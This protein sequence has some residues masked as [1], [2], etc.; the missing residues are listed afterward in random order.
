MPLLKRTLS[1]YVG[2]TVGREP[3]RVHIEALLRLVSGETPDAEVALPCDKCAVCEFG[4]LRLLDRD[5]L[6]GG[7]D[8]ELPLSLGSREFPF[9]V[10]VTVEKVDSS[11]KIHNLSIQS[12]I[13]LY[14]DFDIMEQGLV[15]RRRREGEGLLRGGMHRKLRRLYREAGVPPRWRDRLPLL[16]DGEGIVWAPFVGMRDG[17]Q[18]EGSAYRI[19]V[20]LPVPCPSAQHR[21]D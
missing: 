4:V 12:C 9:G 11:T 7:E 19:T 17:L 20:E 15:W 1:R 18:T 16:C 14:T 10:C 2:E 5:E 8:F 3:E 13:I 21:N 6:D